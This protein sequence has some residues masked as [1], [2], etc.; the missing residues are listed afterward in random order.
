MGLR[1][2]KNNN[3]DRLCMASDDNWLDLGCLTPNLRLK[4][5]YRMQELWLILSTI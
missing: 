2:E 5:I 4:K 3:R 1:K